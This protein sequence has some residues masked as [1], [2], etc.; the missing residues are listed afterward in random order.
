[1]TKILAI[2]IANGSLA[3]IK[4]A[5]LKGAKADKA[6][7]EFVTGALCAT[8]TTHGD[9]SAQAGAVSMLAMM[10]S[11]RGAAYL[12]EYVTKAQNA[13]D[14]TTAQTDATTAQTDATDAT[15]APQTGATVKPGSR[16]AA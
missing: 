9:D 15:D 6:A 2:A 11:V 3:R 4:A 13:T 5:G 16:R 14:A 7:L 12:G 10:V 8:M 1:M